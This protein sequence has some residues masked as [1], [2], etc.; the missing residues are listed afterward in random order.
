MTEIIEKGGT[1]SGARFDAT[2]TYRYQL[3]RRWL[4]GSGMC[5][6]I[7]L[8][9]STATHEED[10]P[11]IRRCIGY[12]KAWGYGGLYVTNLFGLRSTDPKALY[13]HPDPIGPD[14]GVH[15]MQTAKDSQRVVCAW[16]THGKLKGWGDQTL[17]V[18]K[19]VSKPCYLK[20]TKDGIPSHPLYL[21]GELM[22]LRFPDAEVPV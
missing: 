5:N 16:G 10:D 1:L 11:T 14:N 13:S 12:A 18:L 2:E 22:P 19:L 3:W 20:L 21:K 15:V 4:V 6:F 9:P 17:T 7:M 8:N